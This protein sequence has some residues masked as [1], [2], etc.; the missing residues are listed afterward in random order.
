M[1]SRLYRRLF[2]ALLVIIIFAALCWLLL[3]RLG[4]TIPWW[5]PVVGFAVIVASALLAPTMGPRE[6]D[7]GP[8]APIPFPPP[9]DEGEGVSA[10]DRERF[11]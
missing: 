4:V 2:V 10:A 5:V 1:R 9:E 7:D 8:D 11:G 6:D 3:P